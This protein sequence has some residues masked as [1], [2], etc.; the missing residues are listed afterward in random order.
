MA[1]GDGPARTLPEASGEV[2]RGGAPQPM[3]LAVPVLRLFGGTGPPPPGSSSDAPYSE[4]VEDGHPVEMGGGA[5]RN[6]GATC[7]AFAAMRTEAL[8]TSGGDRTHPWP[9]C[10]TRSTHGTCGGVADSGEEATYSA[11]GRVGESM[12][13]EE[14]MR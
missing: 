12:E 10:R 9:H 4:Q 6:A 13:G 7:A 14:V 5:G 11:P 8:S 3:E 2:M 1:A